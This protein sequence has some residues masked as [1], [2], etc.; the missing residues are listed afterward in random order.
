MVSPAVCTATPFSWRKSR[1]AGVTMVPG[2]RVISRSPR[3]RAWS[4]LSVRM[5]RAMARLLS[6]QSL[7]FSRFLLVGGVQGGQDHL[8]LAVGPGNDVDA[9][10][11]AHTGGGG[12][13]GV[14]GGLH[15]A[16]VAADHDGH[17]T[18]A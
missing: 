16:H 3:Q 5:S 17:Q 13:A 8:H 18:A 9:D 14:G 10:Q 15:G 4:S 12:G 7:K 1:A 2:E 6:V 11:L